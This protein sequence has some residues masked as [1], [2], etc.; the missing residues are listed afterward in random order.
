MGFLDK[1]AKAVQ[2]VYKS[3]ETVGTQTYR[4]AKKPFRQYMASER[5]EKVLDKQLKVPRRAPMNISKM[6]FTKG[7]LEKR[8]KKSW[9]FL[10]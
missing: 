3:A 6:E 1:L 2:N 5:A 9:Q 4:K 8:S 10:T 7:R